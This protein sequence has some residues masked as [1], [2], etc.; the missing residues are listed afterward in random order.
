MLLYRNARARRLC[1]DVSFDKDEFYNAAH[2]TDI[3]V[4]QSEWPSTERAPKPLQGFDRLRNGSCG[5][6][7]IRD[8]R[9]SISCLVLIPK[10]PRCMV[11]A[12]ANLSRE[13]DYGCLIVVSPSSAEK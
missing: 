3:Q 11:R 2:A 8:L 6:A 9:P 4:I 10:M 12:A 7:L 5:S 1:A 13:R